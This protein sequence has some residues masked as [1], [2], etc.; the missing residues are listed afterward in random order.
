MQG[1]VQLI[2]GRP[3]HNLQTISWGVRRTCGSTIAIGPQLT[4][5]LGR[6]ARDTVQHLRNAF[7][8]LLIS[9]IG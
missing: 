1:C 9:K 5:L 2:L 6:N 4:R 8:Q 3:K 7:L